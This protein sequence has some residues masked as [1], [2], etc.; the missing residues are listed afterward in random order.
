[1]PELPEVEVTRRSIAPALVGHRLTRVV[2]RVPALRYPLPAD[3]GRMLEHR[4]LADITRRGKYLLLNFDPG[5][6]LIHLGMSGTLRL[7]PAQHPPQKHDHLDLSF[8]IPGSIAP[9]LRLHDPRRFGA[10]LWIEG[11]PLRHPLLA[12]LGVEPLSAPFDAAWLQQTLAQRRTAIKPTLMNN[13]LIVGIG[14]IYAAESLFRAGIDPRR[15]AASLNRAELQRL[16]ESIQTTLHAAIDAGG[17]SLRDFIH[18]DGAPGEFQQ[19]YFVYGRQGLPCRLC[20]TSVL[21][22]QQGQRSTGYCP[23]CQR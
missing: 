20:G 9:L 17:S 21:K 7:L 12:S 23:Q 15:V 18:T 10:V 22:L 1:M 16:V 14:N 8:D 2:A 11:D 4:R 3:L 13:R 19:Q 6:L 5:H